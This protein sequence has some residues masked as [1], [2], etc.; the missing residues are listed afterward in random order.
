MVHGGSHDVDNLALS[1]ATCNLAKGER[2]EAPD[3]V[4]GVDVPLFNPRQQ[5]WRRHFMLTS[6]GFLHGRTPVGRATVVALAMN[7]SLRLTARRI[8]MAN[9]LF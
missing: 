6:D 8:W 4:T 9:G 7:N 5:S 3:P 1:C 2:M